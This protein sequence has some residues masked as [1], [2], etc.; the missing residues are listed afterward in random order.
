MDDLTQPDGA[1]YRA[2]KKRDHS[3]RP[4]WLT[5]LDPLPLP[6]VTERERLESFAR[7]MIAANAIRRFREDGNRGNVSYS[8][9]KNWYAEHLTPAI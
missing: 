9:S 5:K 7:R 8:R 1:V 2:D 6:T 3:L 4:E